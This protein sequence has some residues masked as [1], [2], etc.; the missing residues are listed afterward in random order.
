MRSTALARVAL[1]FSAA[2]LLCGALLAAPA[3][4]T[5][6][7]RVSPDISARELSARAPACLPRCWVAVSFNTK[8]R[9][10]GWTQQGKW[11]TKRRAMN[12]A[13]SHCRNRPVNAGQAR[14]CVRPAARST[15]E[16]NGCVGV[17]NLVR[18]GRLIQW[19]VAKAYGPKKAMR[20]AKRKLDGRGTKSAGAACSPRRF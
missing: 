8:T 15:V 16:R 6:P 2:L 7:D 12:S 4:S 11:G 9:R 14:A 3:S 13:L 10:S 20:K 1:A 17:A 19:T 5:T 18:N